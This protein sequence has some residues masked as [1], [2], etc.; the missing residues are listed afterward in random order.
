VEFI[1]AVVEPFKLVT[2]Y[3]M[4][5]ACSWLAGWKEL[6]YVFNFLTFYSTYLGEYI[7]IYIYIYQFLQE[8]HD[9]LED[10]IFHS[11]CHENLKVVF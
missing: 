1:A 2:A 10:G 4:C 6:R 3:V 5:L 11:H 7:Y 8:P 9:I